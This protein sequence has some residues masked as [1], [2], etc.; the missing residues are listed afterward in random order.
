MQKSKES[1]AVEAQADVPAGRRLVRSL[2]RDLSDP[3]TAL[4]EKDETIQRLQDK[5]RELLRQ[6]QS[7]EDERLRVSMNIQLFEG[8]VEYPVIPGY[9]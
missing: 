6:F 7:A 4:A 9:R 1:G 5:C 2:T 3:T 8:I